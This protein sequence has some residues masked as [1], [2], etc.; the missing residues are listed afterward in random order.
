MERQTVLVVD[1]NPENLTVLCELLRPHC[2]VRAANSGE[3]AL[4]LVRQRPR[5]DLV[6][7]DVMMPDMSGHETLARLRADDQTSDLPVI[8]VTALDS[9]Q[10]EH[11]GLE[12]GAVDFIRKPLQPAVLVAR[13]QSQLAMKRARERLRADKVSLEL[14]LLRHRHENAL[15]QDITLHALS[16]LARTR[17]NETGNHILRTQ[18]SVRLLAELVRNHPR[19]SAALDND[20]IAAIAKSAPLH[21]IGKVAIPDC[22]LRKPGALDAAEWEVMKTHA[23]LGAATIQRAEEDLR[24][25]VSFL[26][27]AKDIARHHHERWDGSGYPDGLAGEAIPLSAR[28]MAVADVFDALV[29]HRVYKPALPF[30]Q[31][32][33][34]MAEQRG[35]HFD[36]D[37]LDAFLGHYELFCD[38]VQRLRDEV[39]D[40]SQSVALA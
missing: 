1:D 6:L 35:R 8:F 19:F 4:R 39:A 17:D 10:D 32:R 27:H 22:I 38:I 29:S 33:V 21:D 13:V 3:R 31:V 26:G 14:E 20:S 28:L 16:Q 12:R 37:L 24:K 9:A 15:A 30:D 34:M 40:E 5:P 25:R 7:L 18:E 36:P 2:N 11:D 23:A